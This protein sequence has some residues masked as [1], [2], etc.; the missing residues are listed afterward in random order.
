M[1]RAEPPVRFPAVQ[2]STVVGTRHEC[3]SFVPF[4]SELNYQTPRRGVVSRRATCSRR[5]RHPRR[6]RGARYS[7]LSA[8][9]G[10]GMVETIYR[11][12]VDRGF[13]GWKGHLLGR[14]YIG[15]RTGGCM[16]HLNAFNRDCGSTRLPVEPGE[17]RL[18]AVLWAHNSGV[19]MVLYCRKWAT[20]M[21]E[22]GH[23]RFSARN[24]DEGCQVT[25]AASDAYPRNMRLIPAWKMSRVVPVK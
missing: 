6:A 15:V 25:G 7:G 11:R 22:T 19:Y 23:P 10:L 8:E 13:S 18:T 4:T 20:S 14:R 12:R 3:Q 21:K 5:R 16:P 1:L 2:R 9:T 17:Q 24:R